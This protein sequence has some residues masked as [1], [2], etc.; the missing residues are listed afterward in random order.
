MTFFQNQYL[1]NY[2]ALTILLDTSYLCLKHLMIRV[3]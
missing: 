3:Y 1:D 2:E